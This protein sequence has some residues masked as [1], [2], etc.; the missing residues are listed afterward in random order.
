[1]V[2]HEHPFP[3]L[4][5]WKESITKHEL[6][7]DYSETEDVSLSSNTDDL[8]VCIDNAMNRR[9]RDITSE[10]RHVSRSMKVGCAE[11]D[12]KA[13]KRNAS[14]SMKVCEHPSSEKSGECKLH[15]DALLS[16]RETSL[17]RPN[18]KDKNG[19]NSKK[20][21]SI[22]DSKKNKKHSRNSG[23]DARHLDATDK[24]KSIERFASSGSLPGLGE[25]D[26]THKVS[27]RSGSLN[28][29]STICSDELWNSSSR[30]TASSLDDDVTKRVLMSF[31]ERIGENSARKYESI[32]EETGDSSHVA[33]RDF[34]YSVEPTAGISP[35]SKP[36]HEELVAYSVPQDHWSGLINRY[37]DIL[38]ESNDSSRIP[39]DLRT[40]EEP[41]R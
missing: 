25:K 41:I 38:E 2:R 16:S 26:V 34:Q 37:H 33:E 9:S 6:E 11:E 1:M 8:I 32:L 36:G 5:P 35:P 31:Y 12:I 24:K 7:N 19:D 27:K 30:S 4:P 21:A 22:T 40:I 10:K 14:R 3:N 18:R 15:L 28:S 13:K 23:S 20:A 29:S 39:S 17:A